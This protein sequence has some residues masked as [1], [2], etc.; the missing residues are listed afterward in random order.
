M[1]NHIPTDLE[2]CGLSGLFFIACLRGGRLALVLGQFFL[3]PPQEVD[4]FY[5][6]QVVCVD[7][8]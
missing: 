3:G 7:V 5:G 2:A 1:T 8:G 4:C 6:G